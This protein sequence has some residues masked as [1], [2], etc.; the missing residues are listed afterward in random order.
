MNKI[1]VIGAGP[2]GITCAIELAKRKFDVVLVESGGER[3]DPIVNG[4]GAFNQNNEESHAPMDIA[5]RR[6]LGG[7]SNIWGGRCVPYDP[8]DFL[9]RIYVPFSKWPITF[10]ELKKYFNITSGYFKCGDEIF[11]SKEFSVN[12][13]LVVGCQDSNLKL[14]DLEKW[15]LPTNF[16]KEYYG[17][18]K[19]H[20]NVTIIKNNTCVGLNER[21]GRVD[22][23]ILKNKEGKKQEIEADQFVFAN[24]TI[25]STRNLLAFFKVKNIDN[26]FIGKYY[27]GHLSGQISNIVFNEKCDV[28]Y[29]VFKNNDGVY[30][31]HRITF[32]ED[33]QVR[34]K[35]SNIAFWLVNPKIGDP[36]HGNGI[37]SFAYLALSSMFG[38]FFAPEAIRRAAIEGAPPGS[39]IK[40]GKNIF[41]GFF[42]VCFFIIVFGFKRFVARRKVPGF[43]QKSANNR[44]P[45]HYHSEQIPNPNSTIVLSDVPDF[46][47]MPR[48]NVDLKFDPIDFDSVVR[49]HQL[50][51]QKLR[52]ANIGHLEFYEGNKFEMVKSQAYDGFH[53]VGTLRMGVDSDHGVVDGNCKVFGF[54]NLYTVNGGVFPTSGQ[55][56]TTYMAVLMGIRLADHLDSIR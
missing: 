51:D 2:V 41:W 12:K 5:M 24:G 42:S 37:L 13:S 17:E 10:A 36:A 48:V 54:K 18:V 29:D 3:F 16:S 52:D 23:V 39:V 34:N 15:S 7:A 47:G 11:S 32:T 53:Q 56:N 26:K 19:K 38:R 14:S 40:H 20:K 6:Q 55:A 9:E 27:M 28:K 22:S 25:E 43:F 30:V 35:I 33:F 21:S 46:L 8:V 49:A 50:L 45:L 44:Y 31:R 4:A 1:L